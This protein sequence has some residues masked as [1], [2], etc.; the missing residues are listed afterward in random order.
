MSLISQWGGKK[1]S[2]GW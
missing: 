2:V 1:T